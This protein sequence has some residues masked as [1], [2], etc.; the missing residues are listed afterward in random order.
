MLQ[1]V[2]QLQKTNAAH[3]AEIT[4]AYDCLVRLTAEVSAVNSMAQTAAAA[5]QYGT[6][7][8]DTSAKMSR[9]LDR[10]QLLQQVHLLCKADPQFK[11]MRSHNKICCP[12]LLGEEEVQDL[13]SQ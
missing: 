4:A 12:A 6:D 11:V 7:K 8:Q 13:P 2:K 3:T 10:A 9:V 1:Q 5:V